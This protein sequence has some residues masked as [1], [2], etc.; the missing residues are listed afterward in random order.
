MRT[1]IMKTV[2]VR[3]FVLLKRSS[4]IVSTGPTIQLETELVGINMP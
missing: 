2:T 3:F 4:E 1:T